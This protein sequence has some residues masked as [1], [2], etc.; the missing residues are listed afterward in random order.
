MGDFIGIRQRNIERLFGE[1][2][3]HRKRSVFTHGIQNRT[4]ILQS[5]EQLYQI[6]LRELR[7]P[8]QIRNIVFAGRLE[9]RRMHDPFIQKAQLRFD[10]SFGCC[11]ITGS[12]Y[13]ASIRFNPC[14]RRIQHFQSYLRMSQNP[15]KQFIIGRIVADLDDRAE[16]IVVGRFQFIV[17]GSPRFGQK[18]NEPCINQ[19]RCIQNTN[20]LSP[21]SL[22][23]PMYHQ[24]ADFI[25]QPHRQCNQ[26]QRKNIRSRR[27]DGS[28]QEDYH[29]G[30]FMVAAHKVGREESQFGEQP[31]EDRDLEDQPHCQRHG[32]QGG[33]VGLKR[34]HVLHLAADL[35]GS[36]ETERQR[37]NQKVADRHA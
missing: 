15:K 28:H 22:S 5:G 27:D 37:E 34:N 24:Y 8:K 23:G 18:A 21:F 14:P 29:D 11:D 30:V 3:Q 10:D 16:K 6:P 7:T 2:H 32:H 13:L 35:I 25:Q 33:D 26:Q 19:S 17:V 36:Q 12:R 31:R 1:C 20:L 9:Q 4:E